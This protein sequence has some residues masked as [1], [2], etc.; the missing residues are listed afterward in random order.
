MKFTDKKKPV[1]TIPH[2][3]FAPHAQKFRCERYSAHQDEKGFSSDWMYQ[4]VRYATRCCSAFVCMLKTPFSMRWAYLCRRKYPGHIFFT[5]MPCG[6]CLLAAIA[7]PKGF[8]QLKYN[9]MGRKQ[10]LPFYA[11]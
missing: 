4:K 8:Q 6:S 11:P 7:L 1:K 2:G 5:N 10:A 3:V 9:A